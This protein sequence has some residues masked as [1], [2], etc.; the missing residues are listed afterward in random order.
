VPPAVTGWPYRS[1]LLAR[2]RNRLGY[3]VFDK[4]VG[5]V[6]R[7]VAERRAAWGLPALEFEELN[8]SP[9]AQQCQAPREFDFPRRELPEVMHFVGPRTTSASGPRC[10]STSPAWT[11]GR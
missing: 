6:V 7:A 5:P 8:A 10:P 11:G 1:S 3:A 2:W 4:M 9:L